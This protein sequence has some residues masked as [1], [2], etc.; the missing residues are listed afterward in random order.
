MYHM[1]GHPPDAVLMWLAGA[2][3]AG[4]AL[5]SNAALMLAVLLYGLWGG[6]EIA[7][8]PNALHLQLWPVAALLGLG[9]AWATGWRPAL[10]LLVV[11]AG[12]LFL[13]QGCR[14]PWRAHLLEPAALGIAAV[15]GGL[16]LREAGGRS[17]EV[18][19]SLEAYGL[20]L[21]YA[22]AWPMHFDREPMLALPLGVWSAAILALTLAAI[23]EAWRTNNRG[24]LW[25]AYAA[26]SVEI[27]SLY[28]KTLGTLLSTS[29]FFL[30]AGLLVIALSACAWMLINRRS[31]LVEAV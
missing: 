31:Y 21:A 27:V 14:D 18:S 3:V 15:L 6:W 12:V 30:C 17:S 25:I 10:H 7:I 9:I 8:A 28:F 1:D 23:L 5:R 29:V 16:I 20:A 24:L 11:I 22:A 26:F 2:C 13:V 4:V 19:Q